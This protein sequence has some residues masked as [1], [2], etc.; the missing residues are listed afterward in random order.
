MTDR[1]PSYVLNV[2]NN[3]T[4]VGRISQYHRAKDAEA[5]AKAEAEELRAAIVEQLWPNGVQET[6]TTLD[7]AGY[8]GVLLC[9][10][11]TGDATEVRPIDLTWRKPKRFDSRGFREAHPDAADAWT[12]ESDTYELRLDRK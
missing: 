8:G 2:L 1:K 12:R 10:P 4:L 11:E 3:E 6:A 9:P 7:E 5:A